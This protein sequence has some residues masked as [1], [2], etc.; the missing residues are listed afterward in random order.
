MIHAKPTIVSETGGLKGIIMD[1]QTDLLMAPGDAKS[2]LAKVDF[3]L[4]NPVKAKEI[5]EKGRQIVKGL[6]GWKR[7]A[8]QTVKVIEDTLLKIRANVN[9]K[10]R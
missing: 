7:I 9:E 10:A 1:K 4:N 8:S 6:Y 2:L 5:G 3:L